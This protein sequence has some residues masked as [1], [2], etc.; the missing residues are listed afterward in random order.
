MKIGVA[1]WATNSNWNGH[2][3]CVMFFLHSNNAV[4]DEQ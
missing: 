3:I 2:D 4:T 1:F